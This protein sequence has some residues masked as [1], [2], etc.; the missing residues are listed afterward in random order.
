MADHENKVAP[1]LIKSKCGDFKSFKEI[2]AFAEKQYEVLQ[3]TL[4]LVKKQ[5]EEIK[6]LKELLDATAELD[7]LVVSIIKSPAEVVLFRQ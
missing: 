4:L 2:Q 1:F 3:N 7:T 6:H 5:E